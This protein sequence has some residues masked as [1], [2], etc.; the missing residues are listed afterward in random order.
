MSYTD[1]ELINRY[2]GGGLSLARI[3]RG[4]SLTELAM[5]AGI[6]ADR[7]RR[8]EKGEAEFTARE[9]YM[10]AEVLCVP[11]DYFFDGVI[12]AVKPPAGEVTSKRAIA[13]M[14]GA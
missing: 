10:T 7:L 5:A 8:L 13:T 1:D 11:V 4:L 2:I 12:A 3:V 14:A 9:L 6:E